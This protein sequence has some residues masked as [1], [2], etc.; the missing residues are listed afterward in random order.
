MRHHVLQLLSFLLPLCIRVSEGAREVSA[1]NQDEVS[2]GAQT[3]ERDFAGDRNSPAC[4]FALLK[5]IN[6]VLNPAVVQSVDTVSK[7]TL[8]IVGCITQDVLEDEQL[9]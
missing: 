5:D 8:T 9:S 7:A 2:Q 3:L 1:N 4:Q 6:K